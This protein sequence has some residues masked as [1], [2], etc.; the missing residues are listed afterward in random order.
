M[1]IVRTLSKRNRFSIGRYD[2]FDGHVQCPTV[3]LHPENNYVFFYKQLKFRKQAGAWLWKKLVQAQGM[4]A[5]CL[6][7]KI[8]L[9]V[10]LRKRL[11]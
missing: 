1:D 7:I 11:D 3:I 6:F 8:L 5:L 9:G 4:L 10:C 2:K